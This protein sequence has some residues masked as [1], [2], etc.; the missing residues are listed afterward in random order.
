MAHEEVDSTPPMNV[1]TD[2]YHT[3]AYPSYPHI[4]TIAQDAE[5]QRALIESV[6]GQEVDGKFTE[7]SKG[8]WVM[9]DFLIFQACWDV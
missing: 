4:A 5:L 8:I 3:V 9:D 1:G 2:L 6:T 7:L